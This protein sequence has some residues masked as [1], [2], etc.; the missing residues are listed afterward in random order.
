[1]DRQKEL[2]GKLKYMI[3]KKRSFEDIC[4]ELELQPY[5]VYGLAQLLKQQGM[6]LVIE[7]GSI[8]KSNFV[9]RNEDVTIIK[10]TETQALLFVSDTHLGSKYDRVDLLKKAY[11]IASDRGIKTVLHVGDMTDGCYPNRAN[12]VYELR[13]HGADEQTDYV[14]QNYPYVQGMDTYFITGNH[15]YTHIRNDGYDIG[16]AIDRQREDMHYLGPDV[17]DVQI[18]KLRIR[19]FHGSKGPAYAKSY[20]LQKYAETIPSEEKPDILLQGHYHNSFYMR[21]QDIDCFQVPALLDQTP[22]ARQL[23]MQNEKGVW[24]AQFQLDSKGNMISIS[25][26]LINFTE[27]GNNK[28]LTLKKRK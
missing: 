27:K 17:A 19:L 1:M 26:E 4:N 6:N 2:L 18:G 15:D 13:A 24:I 25:P 5:E 11:K 20:K 23:G 22:Y 14:V 10:P 9:P 7:E 12:Q 3:N 21:Y 28:R 8:T 16:K